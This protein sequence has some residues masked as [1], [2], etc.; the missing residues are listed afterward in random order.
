SDSTPRA[1]A[2]MTT[3]SWPGIVVGCPLSALRCP[4]YTPGPRRASQAWMGIFA[5]AKQPRNIKEI[6]EGAR[7][8]VT[9]AHKLHERA[10]DLHHQAE[11]IHMKAIEIHKQISEMHNRATST[12]KK[13]QKLNGKRAK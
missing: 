12:R 11:D 4:L 5:M 3:I 2:P 6:S 9:R 10:D 7:Q 8:G 13:A 1:E